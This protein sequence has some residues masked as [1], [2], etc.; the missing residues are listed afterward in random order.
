MLINMAAALA[1]AFISG[2]G[3]GGGG[4]F[5]VYLAVFSDIPQLAVQGFNLVFFLFS[6][7][8]SV[9]VQAFRRKINFSAVLVM[10]VAGLV[11]A[12]GGS[13]LATVVSSGLLR[14]VFGIMLT[15]AGIMSL[16]SSMTEKY[17]ENSS[18]KSNV[19]GD[20]TTAKREKDGEKGKDG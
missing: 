20:N 10:T 7:G 11:G 15:A 6:A 9:S 16:K 2:L 13:L 12:V 19:N 4:L 18:T 14:R 8:A 3:I 17:S 1:I 5:A